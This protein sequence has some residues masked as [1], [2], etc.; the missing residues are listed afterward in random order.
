VKC[1]GLAEKTFGGVGQIWETKQPVTTWGAHPQKWPR[2]GGE[3]DYL[4][5]GDDLHERV[6]QK[7]ATRQEM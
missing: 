4:A 3:K 5:G 6:N 1:W 2:F 7:V